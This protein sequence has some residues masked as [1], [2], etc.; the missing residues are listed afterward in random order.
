MSKVENTN[1]TTIGELSYYAMYLRKELVNS[2]SPLK[3]DEAFISQRAE[4]A[5]I[6]C[7][8]RRRDGLTADQAHE[9]AMTVLL[10]GIDVDNVN[11]NR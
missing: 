2:N 9:Y 3:D 6:T 7:E 1:N 11:D 4:E 8:E 10:A 5:E